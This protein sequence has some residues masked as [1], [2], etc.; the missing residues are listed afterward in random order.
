MK[1]FAAAWRFLTI[2]PWPL[3]AGSDETAAL[4]RSPVMFPAVGLAV[5]IAIAVALAGCVPLFPVSVLAALAVLLLAVPSGGLHLDGLA[6]SADALL[7]PGRGREAALAIMRDSR[8]GAHG[9]TALF[10]VLL[11]KY[12]CLSALPAELMVLTV[13]VAPT[14]GRAAMLLPMALLPYARPQGLGGIFRIQ[15]PLALTAFATGWTALGLGLAW[16]LRGGLVGLGAW[17]A[18]V[19]GWTGFLFR[20][21]GGATGDTYGAGCELAETAVCLSAA[22]LAA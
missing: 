22:W 20:R 17:L 19:L 18:V 4:A 13:A 6:D 10:L 7:A 15:D 3:P 11:I 21:L 5:G 9:A 1:R 2:F 8:I 12:A 16:G 14:A